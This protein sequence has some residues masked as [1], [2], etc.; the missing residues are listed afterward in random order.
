S[1]SETTTPKKNAAKNGEKQKAKAAKVTAPDAVVAAP[2]VNA[3]EESFPRGGASALTP[4]EYREVVDQAK[5]DVLFEQIDTVDDGATKPPQKRKRRRGADDAAAEDEDG[6]V[7]KSRGDRTIRSADGLSFKRINVGM[8]ILG[9]IKEINDLELVVSLPHQQTGTVSITEISDHITA[10]VEKAAADDDDD[11]EDDNDSSIPDLRTLFRIGQPVPC[12]VI[13]VEDKTEGKGTKRRIDLSLKPDLV[14][15]GLSRAAMFEGMTL[16]AAVVSQEDHGYVLS[17]G[18]EG[19]TGFLL[20]KN[21][22]KYVAEVNGG[23]PLAI[24]QLVYAAVLKLDEGRSVQFTVDPEA[25]AKSLIPGKLAPTLETLRAGSLVNA[26]VKDVL[27]NGLVLSFLGIFEGTVDWFHVGHPVKDSATD[28]DGQF[29]EGQKL[30]ARLLFVDSANKRVGLTLTPALMNLA[31]HEFA[32]RDTIDIGTIVDNVSV[33]RVDAGFGC[34]LEIPG[35]GIG[36]VHMSK[37]SDA[38]ADKIEKRFRAGTAHRARV[39]GFDYCDGLTL[40]TFQESIINQAYMRYEDIKAG[41]II[42]GKILKLESYG[43]LVE[44]TNNIRGLC[45]KRH[46]SDVELTKPEKM[47]KEGATVKCQVLSVDA[48][49]KRV[50][51]THRK[52]LMGSNLDPITSYEDAKPD[53][54]AYGVISAVRDFGCIVHFYNNVRGLA[55]ISELSDQFIKNPSDHFKVNQV[56]KCRVLSVD[57]ESE[58]LSVSFKLAASSKTGAGGKLSAVEIGEVVSGRI[59]TVMPEGV[60]VEIAPSKVRGYIPKMHLTDHAAHAD[61]LLARFREGQTLKNLVVVSKDQRKSRVWVSMKPLLVEELKRRKKAIAF[62]DIKEGDVVPGYVKGILEAGCLIALPGGVVGMVK[63]HSVSDRFVSNIAEHVQLDQTVIASVSGIDTELQRVNLSLKQSQLT[64]TQATS[65]YESSYLRSFFEEE[66]LIHSP[67][68]RSAKTEAKDARA[69][70]SKFTIGSIVEGK[71]K[72]HLPFGTILELS[73]DVSGLLAASTD[74]PLDVEAKVR[75]RIMDV[76]VEKKIVDLIAVAGKK[77]QGVKWDGEL[78]KKLNAAKK[79]NRQLDA[80]VEIVKEDYVILSLPNLNNAVA[81]ALAKGFN[82]ANQNFTRYRVGQT[83]EV[84]VKEIPAPQKDSPASGVAKQRLLVAPVHKKPE[85]EATLTTKRLVKD[86]IDGEIR[87]LEDYTPGRLTKGRVQSIKETQANITLGSN[88]KGRI[89]ITELADNM[90][91]IEDPNRPFRK[92]VAAG[93]VIECKVIGFHDA[94]SRRFLPFSHKN[95]I[96]KTVVELTVRPSELALP[97]YELSPAATA[98]LTIET[99]EV[100]SKYLGFVQS[101]VEDAIWVLIGKNLLG[102]VSLFEMSDNVPSATNLSKTFPIGKAV[103]VRVL[104]KNPE[105]KALDLSLRDELDFDTLKVGTVLGGRISKINPEQGVGLQ[106]GSNIYATAYLTDLRDEYRKNPTEGFEKGQLVMCC[107]LHVDKEKKRVE[108]SL[109]ASRVGSAP[110]EEEEG[111]KL[112]TRNEQAA[113][114]GEHAEEIKDISDLKPD[115]V[116]AGYVHSISEKGCFVRLNRNLAARVKIGELSDAFIKDWKSAFKPGQLVKGRIM[117]VNTD[118]GHVEMALKNSLVDPSA[119]TTQITF[120][121]LRKG[122]KVK[123]TVTRIEPFGVFIHIQNSSIRGLCHVTQLSDTPV[124]KIDKLYSVGDPVKAYIIKVDPE[125]KKVSF[126]LKASYFEDKDIEDEDEEMEEAAEDDD[127]EEDGNEDAEMEDAAEE[128]DDD[129]D[130]AAE[131]EEEES[132][133]E[134]GMEN[135]A[136]ILAHAQADS[137]VESDG[138]DAGPDV[139]EVEPLDIGDFNW[140]ESEADKAPADGEGEGSESEE[141]YDGD[142]EAKSKKKSRRAKQRAKREEEERIARKEVSL[143]EGDQAPEVAEDFERLLLGSPNSSYLWI[144]FMAFQLQMAEVEKARAVAERALKSISFRE[145]QEKM[146]V[147]VAWM[148][149]ENS[150]GTQESLM[151]VF[152]RATQ[153]ND[154]KATYMHLVRIYERSQKWDLAEKLYQAMSK[155]FK[156]SSKVWTSMGLFYLKQGKVDESRKTLQRSLQSLAKRKHVKTICKFAQM[157]FKY[158]EPERGRTIF[159]GIMSNYPKRVDLWSIYLDME[160]RNGD[161]DITR[162]LFERVIHLK[163]SSKK[164]KFFFK[165]YLEFEKTRGT[166]EGVEHVR[167]AARAYVE[168]QQ[169]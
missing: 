33:V 1:A 149:L 151:K 21:A 25:V 41:T 24:G 123:G 10:Q 83:L 42:K 142:D 160:I 30:R 12:V 4:L 27:D 59:V 131:G 138:D 11:D 92:I 148:N 15:A 68:E 119:D 165:K 58:K 57:P 98:P 79:E 99:V 36:Y 128:N 125:K 101:S 136:E 56:V 51:L 107:V 124:T 2:V 39:I 133:D 62:E 86:P 34:L 72:K 19:V 155:R 143:L 13:A 80:V 94:H 43:V 28:L 6:P 70:L 162:R 115:A 168:Q 32:P 88:L 90:D 104:K 78:L 64:A 109:R 147:W 110:E 74:N 29:K 38:H 141:S 140:G 161:S 44:I 5:Q 134:M 159:E 169:Q 167:Q 54:I 126:G 96:S 150:Y 71:V 153:M 35:A 26:K 53:Q 114:V 156:E 8:T 31:P 14:N 87:T 89:H 116:V 52:S 111:H 81:Y 7:K 157:E 158:G 66:D 132:E 84:T 139:N 20:R 63:L 106:L 22:E 145:E 93:Q 47:F 91:E 46:L 82:S 76:A 108:V 144:K 105:K 95:P 55:P 23:N 67:A 163:F 40:V 127:V 121:T 85:T 164:V 146:N 18:I 48:K 75:G 130:E 129:D 100:G 102:R 97:N 65:V 152:E 9:C 61:K 118:N 103:T 120:A 166:E 117:S 112:R 50:A 37:L 16:T 3:L 17:A 137:D 69:W 77:V 49:N 113:T 45:P 135:L 154:A 60:L 73:D 122:Q